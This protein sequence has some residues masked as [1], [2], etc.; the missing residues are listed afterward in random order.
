VAKVDH[1]LYCYSVTVFTRHREVFAALRGMSFAAQ[2]AINRYVTWKGT[3]EAIWKRRHYHAKFHFTDPAFRSS[4]LAWAT[5]F[6][7]DGSWTTIGE[8][9]NDPLS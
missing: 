6:L 2:D 8:S 4:F 1:S 9:D 5:Q 3:T 7:K